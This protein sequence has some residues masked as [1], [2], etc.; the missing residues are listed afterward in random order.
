MVEREG[1]KERFVADRRMHD[2]LKAGV[3][4]EGRN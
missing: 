1:R 4:V 3:K 2:R